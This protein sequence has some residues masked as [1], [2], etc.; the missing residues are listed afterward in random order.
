MTGMSTSEPSARSMHWPPSAPAGMRGNEPRPAPA[1]RRRWG[2]PF[3]RGL[4]TAALVALV[5]GS[6]TPATAAEVLQLEEPPR[7]GVYY[8]TAEPTFYTGFAPRTLE[9]RRMHL[10]VGRGNQLRVTVVLGD[11]VL[12]EYPRDLLV[13]QKVYR[14]LV[15]R[16]R[17][18]LTQNRS[19]DEFSRRLSE[20][21]VAGLVAEEKGLPEAKVRERNLELLEKLNPGRVFRIRLPVDDLLRSW[22]LE[23]RAGGAA[24]KPDRARRLELLN[25]L[26]PTRLF[27]S[28]IDAGTSAQLA[29]LAEKAKAVEVLA[30]GKVSARDLDALRPDYLALL[31]KVSGGIYPVRGGALVFDEFTA[32]YPIG[33]W[34]D[35]TTVHGRKI[36]AYPTPG[37]RALTTHQRT[38][39]P[40]H[41]PTVMSYSYS[42]WLP[43]MHVGTRM[44]NAFHTLYWKMNPAEASFLPAAWKAV[45]NPEG[46]PRRHLWLLSRGPMSHGCTHVNVGHQGELRQMLPSDPDDLFE[47]DVFLNRSTDYDV[48]DIDGDQV[49]EVMGVK[50]FIAYSLRDDRPHRLRVR[51]DRR[52]YYDWLYAG[53]LGYDDDG[54]GVF[55]KVRDGRF[56]GKLARAGREYEKIRLYEAAYEPEKV[57][58]YRAVD[59]PF[60]QELRRVG[61]R[62]PFGGP[63]GATGGPE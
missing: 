31:E 63:D 23:V 50:Y 11:D 37:K 15:A 16:G 7:Y 62:H 9:A 58:F 39:T 29:A 36:P 17:L 35:T 55:A 52:A 47:V 44:H 14:D 18:T 34:N 27:L 56:E 60:T 61:V 21:D 33:T 2:R 6:A 59:I 38:K 45:E 19:L 46:K 3:R 25:G 24:G 51:N 30:K 8:D 41:V 12:R 22:L 13:R 32:I 54:R 26:L 40:D 10:H 4:R 20:A 57:Q 1:R 43:Y 49:P 28:A 48:F 53:E 5:L 42:P